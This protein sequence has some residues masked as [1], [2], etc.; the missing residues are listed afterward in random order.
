MIKVMKGLT[1]VAEAV[2][3]LSA[4][5]VVVVFMVVWLSPPLPTGATIYC[6]GDR[7]GHSLHFEGYSLHFGDGKGYSLKPNRP[8][9]L[10][11]NPFVS[12]TSQPSA[13]TSANPLANQSAFPWD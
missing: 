11:V 13:G 6:F 2:A 3:V 7:I 8:G 1:V 10:Q 9:K 4:S 5:A 12:L